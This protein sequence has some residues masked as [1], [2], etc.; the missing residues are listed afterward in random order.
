M[1]KL[2]KYLLLTFIAA[3]I[4]ECFGCYERLQ[5][6][7]AGGEFFDNSLA[8]AMMIPTLGA[9]L[10]GADM[11][12]MG[13]RLK[14]GRNWKFILFAWLAPTV[15]QFIGALLYYMVF[16]DDFAPA[17]AFRRFMDPE[18]LEIFRQKGSPYAAF[19]FDEIIG[20]LTSL[21]IVIATI[22]ALGEE[23][24][25]RGF[26]YPELKTKYGRTKGL[27]IGG[28][29]HGAWHFPV[30]LLVGY[31]YG[32]DYI[33]AP[34]LGLFVFCMFTVSMG[35]VA[36]FLYTKSG[37]IWL[38]AIFH[39]MINSSVS[40]RILKGDSHPERSIFGPSDIGMIAMLPMAAFAAFLLW[41]QYK[42]E[43]MELEELFSGESSL[44]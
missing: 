37:S 24:G 32:R 2:K 5:G 34:V 28:V 43:Q 6:G 29:I 42:R 27:L 31:E 7:R 17:E 44:I 18:D 21:N 14:P 39:A 30:M 25:W 40:P 12:E 35:I 1:S 22:L 3:W 33:G 19:V 15:F 20:S 23:T 13:W 41:Y 36:D 16:P 8:L 38:P 9:L 26:M 10:A 4:A 11:K